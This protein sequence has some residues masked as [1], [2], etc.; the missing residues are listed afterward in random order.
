MKY[1]MQGGRIRATPFALVMLVTVGSWG[2]AAWA[3]VPV[4]APKQVAAADMAKPSDYLHQVVPGDTLE[5]LARRLMEEPRRYPEIARYNQLSDS[6][7]LA[8]GQVLRFPLPYLKM[9][10]ADATITATKGQ[11]TVDGRSVA[12]GTRVPSQAEVVTA[13][14]GQTTLKLADGS[15]IRIQPGSR[16]KIDDSRT[17]A[18]TGSRSIRLKLTSGRIETDVVPA[19]NRA[20]RYEIT[21]PTAAL[22]V[23]GTSF[24][25]AALESSATTEVLEGKVAASGATTAGN[26]AVDVNQGFGTITAQGK[27]PLPP[28]AL[29][30]APDVARVA[31]LVEATDAELTF[32]GV[33]GARQYRAIVAEDGRFERIIHQAVSPEPLLRTAALADGEYFFRARAI[34]AQGL[35]GWNADHRFRVKAN[36]RPPGIPDPAPQGVLRQPTLARMALTFRWDEVPGASGYILQTAADAGFSVDL[37]EVRVNG[38]RHQMEIA[39]SPRRVVYWRVRTLD[40][41]GESGPAGLA[42]AFRVGSDTL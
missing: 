1:L 42:Q 9:A 4:R 33:P 2:E 30:R 16:L 13:N 14:D 36:P 28:T 23:R 19:A 24:R 10:A 5:R 38:T 21:T 17:N 22:A 29:L 32:G 6:D 18:Y 25:A 7:V 39:S 15:E 20:S 8:P 26:T 11:V 12:V 37:A 41:K 3:Q 27:P 35:E 40:A 31:T 34:D